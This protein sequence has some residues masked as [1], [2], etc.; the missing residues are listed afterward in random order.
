MGSF[1]AQVMLI[2]KTARARERKLNFLPR[3]LGSFPHSLV[4]RSLLIYSALISSAL[5]PAAISDLFFYLLS[6]SGFS[7]P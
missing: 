4:R 2:P 3:A 1:M 6:V 7:G 5:T